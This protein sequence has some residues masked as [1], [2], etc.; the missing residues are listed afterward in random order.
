[1]GGEG[2]ARRAGGEKRMKPT[3]RSPNQNSQLGVQIDRNSRNRMKNSAPSAGP[4]KLRMPPITTM[5]TSSPENATESGS[6]EA[7]RGLNT[8]SV[9][10]SATTQ[11]DS[12]KAI[13]L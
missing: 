9:P 12:K 1:G 7:K 10:A 11:T 3:N 8:D 5:A 4:R 6:A 13:S 2:R